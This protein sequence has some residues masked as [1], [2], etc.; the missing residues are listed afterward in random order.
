[1]SEKIGFLKVFHSFINGYFND[2][3]FLF[4]IALGRYSLRQGGLISIT[5]NRDINAGLHYLSVVE[6]QINRKCG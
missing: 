2:S 4:R 3:S 5:V 6:V 1:M